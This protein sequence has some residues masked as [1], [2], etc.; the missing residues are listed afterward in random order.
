[1][2]FIKRLKRISSAQKKIIIIG[3]LIT[4]VF[5]AAWFFMYLPSKNK[6]EQL[7]GELDE[8]NNQIE[9]IESM[10]AKNKTIGEGIQ[11]LKERYRQ[12]SDR[13]PEKEEKALTVLFDL[14]SKADIDIA[15]VRSQVKGPCKPVVSI[16]GKSCQ[17]LPV[18][19][20]INGSYRNLVAYIELLKKSLPAYVTFGKLVVKR[21]SQASALSISLD[22]RIY[23]LS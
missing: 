9:Q 8:I 16:E 2:S 18:S 20:Q 19:L 21:G 1:M 15:S 4:A 14:A 3:I 12:L 23:L 22:I 17:Q 7:K 5:I 6:I 10:V 13:F 11:L